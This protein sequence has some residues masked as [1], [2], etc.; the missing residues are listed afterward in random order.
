MNTFFKFLLILL[1]ASGYVLSQEFE[2][3]YTLEELKTNFNK[4]KNVKNTG[5]LLSGVGAA[6]LTTGIIFVSTADWRRLDNTSV[7]PEDWKGG[8]G[9]TLTLFG[10]PFAI[11]GIV[12]I[13]K[14][15]YK[16]HEFD[17]RIKAFTTYNHKQKRLGLHLTYNIR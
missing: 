13:S 12:M 17:S 3:E 4:Y 8:T 16:T 14:G 15:F 6:L 11:T 7:T 1:T 2:E 9:A 5:F 10:V